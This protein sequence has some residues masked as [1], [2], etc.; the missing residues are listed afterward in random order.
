MKLNQ[1]TRIIENNHWRYNAQLPMKCRYQRCKRPVDRYPLLS[2]VAT[3]C[4]IKVYHIECARLL[5][6]I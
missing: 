2:K 6:I 5:H 3:K 1:H 4:R